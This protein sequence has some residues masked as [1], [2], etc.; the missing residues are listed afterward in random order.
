MVMTAGLL[1]R[2]SGGGDGT[3]PNEPSGAVVIS[4]ATWASLPPLYPSIQA[5][6][7]FGV[8]SGS[9]SNLSIIT[10]TTKPWTSA[11]NKALRFSYPQGADIGG[12]APNTLN[13]DFGFRGNIVGAESGVDEIYLDFWVRFGRA[14]SGNDLQ[15]PWDDNGN[16]GTKIG[17]V[18]G[19]VEGA[20]ESHFFYNATPNRGAQ[21]ETAGGTV[22]TANPAS[23]GFGNSLDWYPGACIDDGSWQRHIIYAKSNTGTS[24]NGVFRYWINDTSVADIDMSDVKH[25]QNTATK[26]WATLLISPTYGGGTNDPP[27]NLFMDF[28]P[29]YVSGKVN[30]F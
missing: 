26:R 23:H 19:T 12:G 6:S 22:G 3:H 17:F 10:P 1:R 27:V 14:A 7:N 20:L 28:G 29:F 30:G 25:F 24:F 5:S 2:A 9:T 4:D 15:G 13:N 21:M 18:L 11:T 8:D 16:V